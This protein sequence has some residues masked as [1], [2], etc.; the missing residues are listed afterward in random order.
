MHSTEYTKKIKAAL[1]AREA[2]TVNLNSA[3]YQF[4]N[5][6]SPYPE[7]LEAAREA[8][9]ELMAVLEPTTEQKEDRKD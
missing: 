1:A 3:I 9:S 5:G 4:R 6:R 8:F 7:H 2:L